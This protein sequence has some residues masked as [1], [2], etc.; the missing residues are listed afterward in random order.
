LKFAIWCFFVFLFIFAQLRA[1][2]NPVKQRPNNAQIENVP[3]QI[4]GV[5]AKKGIVG[6]STSDCSSIVVFIKKD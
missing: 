3:V 4:N 6:G 5:W 1:L 2:L